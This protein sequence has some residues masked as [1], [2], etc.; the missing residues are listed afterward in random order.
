MTVNGT[1]RDAFLIEMYK[2]MWDNINRHIGVIW[3]SMTVLL[4]A[5]AVFT[6]VE[7][8][9][10]PIDFAVALVVIVAAWQVAHVYDASYWVNRNLLIIRNLERQFLRADDL[11]RI[12]YYFGRLRGNKLIEHFWI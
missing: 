7:R 12:H 5:G 6:L 11:K 8:S 4:G 2:A 3:H 1:S 9:I 10:V